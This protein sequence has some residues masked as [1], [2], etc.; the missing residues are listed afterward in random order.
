MNEQKTD[1]LDERSKEKMKRAKKF[2][3][4]LKSKKGK[5]DYKILSK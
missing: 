3:K 2:E 4:R 5:K 1:V